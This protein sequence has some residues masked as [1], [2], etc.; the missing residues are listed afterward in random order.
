MES[1]MVLEQPVIIDAME[2]RPLHDGDTDAVRKLFKEVFQHDM[3]PELWQWKYR[4]QDGRA[5]GVFKNDELVCHYGGV[6]AT[7]MYKGK[8]SKALQSVD[9]MVKP[10]A[11][12]GVRKKSAFFLASVMF[13]E[14][15]LGY[16]KPYLLGYGFPSE[17]AMGLSERMGIFAPVGQMAEVL[18]QGPASLNP[19]PLLVK[20]TQLTVANFF[21]HKAVLDELWRQF[22]EEMQNYILVQKDAAFL[23]Q[24]YLRHPHIEYRIVLIKARLTG[25]A[26]GTI[27]LKKEA[28]RVLLMDCIGPC[29]NFPLM[30]GVAMR[31]ALQMERPMLVAW[32]SKQFTERFAINGATTRLLPIITPANTWTTAPV[33]AELQDR[34]W[35][36]PGD[37][38]YL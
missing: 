22:S 7:I 16:G 8:L 29:K 13:V 34:W 1:V 30:L 15:F 12:H 17:R 23:E 20:T 31:Q 10:S 28:E 11:R 25:K 3:S 6:G 14:Q 37:T 21:S 27:V 24:R 19:A 5:V 26:L 2:V 9:L 36:M 35:L 33:P 38:D 32:C 18:W 4:L